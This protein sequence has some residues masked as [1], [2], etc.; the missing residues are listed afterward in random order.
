MT[1]LS[2][3]R[4]NYWGAEVAYRLFE[5]AQAA[6]PQSHQTE[7]AESENPS[8]G[9]DHE[10]ESGAVGVVLT[11]PCCSLL[12]DVPEPK[13]PETQ[14]T[15][16]IDSF[17]DPMSFFSDEFTWGSMFN[18]NSDAESEV[19]TMVGMQ[20]D[21]WRIDYGFGPPDS[22]FTKSDVAETTANST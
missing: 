21:L 4:D 10:N 13:S 5:K 6:L 11:P 14:Q 1:V 16:L 2:Q 3:L 7:L 15:P 9:D 22:E 19:N 20:C 17:A 18:A 12:D 8:S